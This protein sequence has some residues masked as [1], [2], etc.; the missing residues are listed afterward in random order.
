MFISAARALIAGPLLF[1]PLGCLGGQL[2]W[3]EERLAALA[4]HGSRNAKLEKGPNR[5]RRSKGRETRRVTLH[6]CNSQAVN[7][8]SGQKCQRAWGWGGCK[9]GLGWI[10]LVC[11][12]GEGGISSKG[13][14]RGVYL[15]LG[16]AE[17]PGGQQEGCAWLQQ[18]QSDVRVCKRTTHIPVLPCPELCPPP[19]HTPPQHTRPHPK[20]QAGDPI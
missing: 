9:G 10:F 4:S 18:C 7:D 6:R 3:L 14:S 5:K 13:F 16:C 12:V 20:T 8:G 11:G 2:G 17:K 15:E 19:Q 1:R